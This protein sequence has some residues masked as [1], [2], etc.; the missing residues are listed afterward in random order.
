MAQYQYKPLSLKDEIRCLALDPGIDSDPLKCSL[1]HRSLSVGPEYEALSY[2]WGSSTKNHT[3]D[4]EG[5]PMSITM[6]LDKCLRQVRSLTQKR[7]LWADSICINQD[8]NEEK[9]HQVALMGEIYRRAQRVLITLGSDASSESQAMSAAS[10]VAE[11]ND[12]IQ[13]IQT[14][15][16]GYNSFPFPDP[17]DP[18]L[19]DPRWKALG[20]LTE[21]PWFERGW[22]IQEAVL[23]RDA[24]VIWGSETIG[25]ME[26]SRVMRW[27]LSRAWHLTKTYNISFSDLHHN[28]WEHRFEKESRVFKNQGDSPPFNTLDI[29]DAGREVK[30]TDD[31]DRVYGFLALINAELGLDDFQ[32]TYQKSQLEVYR[33]FAI[34]YMTK[35]Q[36]LTL[37][38]F[39]ANNTETLKTSFPSWVPQWQRQ[40]YYAAT[41]YA[42]EEKISSASSSQIEPSI[43]DNRF[44]K[45]HGVLFDTVRAVTTAL[46]KSSDDVSLNDVRSAWDFVS[47]QDK[48]HGNA[49]H[50]FSLLDAFYYA[51]KLGL[52]SREIAPEKIE[53]VTSAYLAT[54]TGHESSAQ[55]PSTI[56]SYQQLH[57]VVQAVLQNRQMAVTSRGYLAIVPACTQ[58]EDVCSI[59][60]GTRAP[61]ILR[62]GADYAECYKLVGS[63]FMVSTRSLR[64][65]T[66]PWRLGTG[67]DSN[68]DWR[69]LALQDQDIMLC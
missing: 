69:D 55:D 63:A 54:I 17:S 3:I 15:L 12:M 66:V 51:I 52:I 1:V 37:L 58:P 19:V 33:D 45:T 18:L 32:I 8:D 36:D 20:L 31:R 4:C 22:V 34:F 48:A 9:G 30:F 59:I 65:G 68:E 10:L 7:I 39:V 44:L 14:K 6:N 26:L 43:R 29:L 40:L 62:K 27:L 53:T 25:W 13:E 23:A 5:R 2:V 47:E 21:H 60:F 67:Y 57:H 28:Q 11:V 64:K 24:Q 16:D 61:F 41:L 56:E 46:G 35:T 50:S 38:H 42:H 49:Y